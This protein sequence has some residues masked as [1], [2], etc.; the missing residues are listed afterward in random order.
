MPLKKFIIV[1]KTAGNEWLPIS[2]LYPELKDFL[3]GYE[4]LLEAQR[5]KGRLKSL[6][7]SSPHLD[8]KVPFRI[9][10]LD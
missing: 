7:K 8:K 10:I 9:E 6:T 3:T 1:G 4:S 2:L 5:A